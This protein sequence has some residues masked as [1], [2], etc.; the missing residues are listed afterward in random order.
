MSRQVLGVVRSGAFADQGFHSSHRTHQLGAWFRDN[1]RLRSLDGADGGAGST[2]EN[3][4]A[5]ADVV[6]L[7]QTI[8]RMAEAFEMT[9]VVNDMS[10]FIR[11]KENKQACMNEYQQEYANTMT[12]RFIQVERSLQNRVGQMSREEMR[13]LR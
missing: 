4:F 10:E 12:D 2:G 11:I 13:L 1:E 7:A 6:F 8:Q 5:S 3:A 9:D